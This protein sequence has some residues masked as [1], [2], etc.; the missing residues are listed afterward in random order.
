MKVVDRVFASGVSVF[1]DLLLCLF[2][3]L[4]CD[5]CV[6]LLGVLRVSLLLGDCQ[7]FLRTGLDTQPV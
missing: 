4:H 1:L 7:A 6:D 2:F 5:S 3:Y